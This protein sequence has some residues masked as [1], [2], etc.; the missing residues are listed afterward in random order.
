[1]ASRKRNDD[2]KLYHVTPRK[3][4]ESILR[5][6]LVPSGAFV[7]LSE[8]CDSWRRD[9]DAV[10]EVDIDGL[11]VEMHTFLPELDEITVFGRIEPSRIR[12][13]G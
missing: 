5:D 7:S 9:G 10:L 8:R 1:M 4:V 6:G 12:V 2:L 3:N 11:G 13:I